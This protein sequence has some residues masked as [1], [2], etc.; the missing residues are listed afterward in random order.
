M[1]VL[2]YPPYFPDLVL[3][4]TFMLTKLKGPLKV[5]YFELLEDIQICMIMVLKGPSEN[6][7]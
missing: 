1:K 5:F 3:C 6:Y 2:E 4:G 7:F